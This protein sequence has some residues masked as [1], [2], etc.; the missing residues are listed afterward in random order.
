MMSYNNDDQASV[1]VHRNR[2]IVLVVIVQTG[3]RRVRF[4][5][6]VL[7]FPFSLLLLPVVVGLGLGYVSAG[8]M[9]NRRRRAAIRVGIL[10]S[11]CGA[12]FL[13]RGPGPAQLVLGLLVGWLGIRMVAVAQSGPGKSRT[14]VLLELIT[15]GDV[16]RP[17]AQQTRRPL[18]AMALGG[19]GVVACV[20]LLILGNEWRL[21]QASWPGR[22]LDDQL[23]ALEVAMGAT[24]VH[25]LIVGVAGHYGHSV[26]G[27]QDHPFRSTS[28]TEFWGRRWN[29]MVQNNLDRGFYRPLARAGHPRLGVLAAFAAS[30]VLH[31]LAVGGAGPPGVVALP[32]AWVLLFFL[33]H[34]GAV[35]VEQKLGWHRPPARRWSRAVAWVRT[36]LLFLALSPG[37]IGNPSR[38]SPMLTGGACARRRWAPSSAWSGTHLAT[39]EEMHTVGEHAPRRIARG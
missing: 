28:L 12:P 3:E 4:A 34:G 16:L 29:R 20:V 35:L 39:E 14:G 38:R 32:C 33:L 18:L 6:S 9:T 19:L 30:G 7:E 22:L 21:W 26:R 37:L 2:K 5:P 17:A 27:L 10:M 15:L 1:F 31:I 11:T 24:G 23:V 13:T 25:C 36:L 8:R